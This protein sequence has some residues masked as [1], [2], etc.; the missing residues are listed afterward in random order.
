MPAF[1]FGLL[2]TDLDAPTNS[3]ARPLSGN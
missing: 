3:E 1:T 2:L